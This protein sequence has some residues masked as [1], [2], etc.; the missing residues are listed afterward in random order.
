MLAVFDNHPEANA[1]VRD[2]AE[3]GIDS[4]RITVLRGE[5]G[6]R[7][8]D[9]RGESGLWAKARQAISFALVDQ[10]PDFV[11]YEAALLDGRTVLAVPAGRKSLKRK[12][13]DRLRARGAHFVNYFGRFATEEIDR[14]RGPELDIPDHLRR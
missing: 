8:L 2:L 13:V 1:A 14:W 5:E 11:L 12:V 6:A 4:S 3:L 9:A 10:M 7:R